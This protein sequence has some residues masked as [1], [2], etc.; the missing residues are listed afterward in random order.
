MG[1]S[2]YQH[3]HVSDQEIGDSFLDVPVGLSDTNRTAAGLQSTSLPATSLQDSPRRP[4]STAPRSALFNSPALPGEPGKWLIP[5]DVP[6]CCGRRCMTPQHP[7]DAFLPGT[8]R[9]KADMA[10]ADLDYNAT[11]KDTVALKY[12]YQHDPTLA[13]YAFS[14][15]PGFTEHLDSGAQVASIN[16]TYLVKPNLSTQETF[17]FMREKT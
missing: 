15:V 4:T 14:S 16:N 5:N 6:E 1:L 7:F 3:L 10:V 17:G 12:Y 11:K 8:G 2:A 9:F 13:P